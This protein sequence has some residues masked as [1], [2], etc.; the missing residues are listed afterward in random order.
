MREYIEQQKSQDLLDFIANKYSLDKVN[1]EK[2]LKYGKQD[3]C[4]LLFDG[5]DQV[6]ENDR[7]YLVG[8]IKD[9]IQKYPINDYIISCRQFPKKGLLESFEELKLDKLDDSL[10]KEFIKKRLNAILD[11]NTRCDVCD[12]SE[13]KKDKSLSQK[14]NT[15][16]SNLDQTNQ[17][18]DYKDKS[19]SQKNN[20]KP[21]NLDQTKQLINHLELVIN[22]LELE[23]K[24][25]KNISQLC[26]NPLMLALICLEYHNKGKRKLNLPETKWA[27]IREAVAI[28]LEKWNIEQG[29][30]AQKAY[31]TSFI[32]NLL[33]F[34]AY[35]TF[36]DSYLYLSKERLIKYIR[37]FITDYEGKDSD[38]KYQL[39][40]HA[41]NIFQA[42]V[43]IYGMTLTASKDFYSFP[44]NIFRNYFAILYI[45][46]NY[47]SID[48]F[49]QKLTDTATIENESS[50]NW[51]ELL[52]DADEAYNFLF[53][54]TNELN[55]KPN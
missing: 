39:Y 35:K 22:D 29:W 5:L 25:N 55:G 46:R 36:K 1:L 21:N 17:L 13:E 20:N 27:I 31:D 16:S 34:I 54:G 18:I 37:E 12:V 19:L 50:N 2:I 11:K 48:E 7:D 49:K 45:G 40:A 24:E 23:I 51:Q 30:E 41:E 26:E 53:G 38:G 33:S 3:K 8:Q 52:T 42:I 15:K 28:W 6:E 9:F 10:K 47:Q 32:E 4:L 43:D 14:D 44:H